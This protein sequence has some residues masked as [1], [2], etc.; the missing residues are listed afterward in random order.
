MP[1]FVKQQ[2][3]QIGKAGDL[4]KFR[5]LKIGWIGWGIWWGCIRGWGKLWWDRI[6]QK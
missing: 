6:S 5:W 1:E 3:Q 4:L 2:F